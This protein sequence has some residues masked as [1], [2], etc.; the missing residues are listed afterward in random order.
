[1]VQGVY[2]LRTKINIAARFSGTA[3]TN[4]SEYGDP[5]H[6]GKTAV[7]FFPPVLTGIDIYI[8]PLAYLS[9]FPPYS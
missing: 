8:I 5:G 9:F 4:S 3:S 6:L 2:V 1:M 7:V